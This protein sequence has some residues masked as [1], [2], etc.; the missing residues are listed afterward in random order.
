MFIVIVWHKKKTVWG[1]VEH[2]ILATR[3]RKQLTTASLFI[4]VA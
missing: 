3:K 2:F 1:A 4:R